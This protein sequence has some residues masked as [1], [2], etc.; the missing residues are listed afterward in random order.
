RWLR[1]FE[2]HLAIINTIPYRKVIAGQLYSQRMNAELF[3]I[4]AILG[5]SLACTGIF[6]VVSLSVARRVREIGVRKAVGATTRSVT[7]LIV[8]QA[9]RPVLVGVGIGIATSALLGRLLQGLLYGVAPSDPVSLALGV[10][11]IVTLS[12]AA[13]MGAAGRATSVPPQVA[14][15]ADG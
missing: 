13:A 4:L 11:V 3:T 15:R 10:T 1:E 2:P 14:L 9:L 12:V 6:G 5:L 8:G 7:L